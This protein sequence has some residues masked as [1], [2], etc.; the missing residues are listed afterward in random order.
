MGVTILS[1]AHFYI[2]QRAKS[3]FKDIDILI[4]ALH[5]KFL[6]GVLLKILIIIQSFQKGTIFADTLLEKVFLILQQRDTALNLYHSEEIT[7]SQG[8]GIYYDYRSQDLPHSLAK[9]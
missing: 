5:M 1:N 6:S 8:Y 7:R 3:I 9:I 2:G 4:R